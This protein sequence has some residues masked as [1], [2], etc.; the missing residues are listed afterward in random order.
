M[1]MDGASGGR[2]RQRPSTP[3]SFRDGEGL[4]RPRPSMTRGVESFFDKFNPARERIEFNNYLRLSGKKKEDPD[5]SSDPVAVIR[6]VMCLYHLCQV[7][8]RRWRG[9]VAGGRP[10]PLGAGC[11]F[12]SFPLCFV[13]SFSSV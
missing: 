13:S 8:G 9:L 11:R 7:K 5:E 1:E 12:C 2:K 6:L 4:K 10:S 3:R